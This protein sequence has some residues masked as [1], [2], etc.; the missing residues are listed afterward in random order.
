M[1]RLL[2]TLAL[3]FSMAQFACAASVTFTW[4][5][6]YSLDP[7]CTA[8][9]TSNCVKGFAIYALDA[10]QNKTLVKSVSNPT[11][12]NVTDV[13][14]ISSAAN[15]NS[16]GTASFTIVAQALDGAGATVESDTLPI[17]VQVKPGK[18]GNP[19]GQ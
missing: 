16:Y 13:V 19:K 7:A 15:V 3:L 12:A 17:N 9:R 18:P 1:K 10:A 5:Y 8:T 14:G 11:G 6:Q 4:D 2:L